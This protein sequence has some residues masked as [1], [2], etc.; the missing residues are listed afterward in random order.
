MTVTRARLRAILAGTGAGLAA[1]YAS[2]TDFAGVLHGFCNETSASS[3]P[4][5][6]VTEPSP[7]RRVR[8]AG[9]PAQIIRCLKRYAARETYHYLRPS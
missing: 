9:G 5:P 4:A 1:A 2:V 6:G 7:R 3:S 8:A